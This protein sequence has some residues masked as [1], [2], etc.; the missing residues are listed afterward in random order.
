MITITTKKILVTAL[1]ILS[2]VLGIYFLQ[3]LSMTFGSISSVYR[4]DTN[5]QK[6][7]AIFSSLFY[8]ILNLILIVLLYRG[9]SAIAEIILV[10][11]DKEIIK[12]KFKNSERKVEM[13]AIKTFTMFILADMLPRLFENSIKMIQ[14]YYDFEYIKKYFFDEGLWLFFVGLC[15]YILL[16]QEFD[17]KKKQ[18]HYHK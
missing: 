15:I 13:L 9:A 7:I 17:Y 4:F 5:D 10:G 11:V 3:S 14:Y 18:L 12:L 16:S 1:R 8:S 6:N 2:I